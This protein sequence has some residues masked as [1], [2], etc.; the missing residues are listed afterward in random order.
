MITTQ[1]TSFWKLHRLAESYHFGGYV[2]EVS[3]AAGTDTG[4]YVSC[5]GGTSSSGV[6]TWLDEAKEY[7]YA[8]L[9]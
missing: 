9:S 3:D 1:L 2:F 4:R 7:G 8:D 5:I 6:N